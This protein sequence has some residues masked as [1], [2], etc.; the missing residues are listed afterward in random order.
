MKVKSLALTITAAIINGDSSSDPR[1]F[2]GFR[3]RIGGSQLVEATQTPG[4]NG[5]LSLFQLDE[6]IDT[7]DGVTH[8]IMS[9]TMR[10]LI[11]SAVRANV[12]GTVEWDLDEFGQR[13][14]VYNGYPILIVDT[15]QDDNRII[16]FNEAGPAGGSDL[17]CSPSY[18]CFFHYPPV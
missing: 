5:P 16:Q 2:D 8:I 11:N 10:N 1:E 6:A 9:K 14:A 17:N 13:F 7:V 15:D 3:V 12:G 4:S 18:G